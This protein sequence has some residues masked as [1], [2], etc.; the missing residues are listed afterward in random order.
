MDNACEKQAEVSISGTM[1]T[2]IRLVYGTVSKPDSVDNCSSSMELSRRRAASVAQYLNER[3][4]DLRHVAVIFKGA[5]FQP[6]K[7]Q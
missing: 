4:V 2:H 7:S 1:F 5:S 6:I 3:E